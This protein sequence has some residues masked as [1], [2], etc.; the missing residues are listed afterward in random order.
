M[1]VPCGDTEAGASLLSVEKQRTGAATTAA[2]AA[3]GG[4]QANSPE[5]FDTKQ[6]AGAPLS[7]I[8]ALKW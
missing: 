5:A 8:A 7:H 4:T 2:T 6:V 1:Y 3:A